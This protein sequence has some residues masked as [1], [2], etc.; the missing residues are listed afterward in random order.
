MLAQ[1]AT[2]R[3]PATTV[4]VGGWVPDVPNDVPKGRGPM[5]FWWCG[6]AVVLATVYLVWLL[7]VAALYPMCIWFGKLKARSRSPWLAYL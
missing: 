3:W 5:L 1:P 4:P 7:V 2:R 6:L